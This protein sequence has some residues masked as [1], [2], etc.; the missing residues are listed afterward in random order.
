MLTDS[1]IEESTLLNSYNKISFFKAFFHMS[2]NYATLAMSNSDFINFCL[3]NDIKIV[4]YNYEYYDINNY[5]IKEEL[6]RRQCENELQFQYC[7]NW[8]DTYNNKIHSLDFTKP[9][10][11]N[12]FATFGPLI[13]HSIE[14]NNWLDENILSANATFEKFQSDNEEEL[15][16]LLDFEKEPLKENSI[17]ELEK[18]LLSDKRFR[19]CS[20]HE[21]RITYMRDFLKNKNNQKYLLLYHGYKYAWERE[22]RLIMLFDQIYNE[23]RGKCHKLK[24]QIGDPLPSDEI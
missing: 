19:F 1:I 12:L 13:I 23:Y 14:T 17:E 8:V 4:F 18:L 24:L 10:R 16:N 7:K 5:L 9:R 15:V 2:Q 22:R 3:K 6:I 20:S 21:K 11:L